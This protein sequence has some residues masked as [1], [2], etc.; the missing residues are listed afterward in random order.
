[1]NIPNKVRAILAGVLLLLS[2]LLDFVSSVLSIGVDLVVVITAVWVL[3]PLVKD[4]F[5]MKKSG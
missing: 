3:W 4:S 2:V 5:T 1:M